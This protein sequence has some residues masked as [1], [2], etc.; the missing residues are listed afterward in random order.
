LGV[1]EAPRSVI[2]GSENK[3]RAIERV[4][5]RVCIYYV[6]LLGDGE[7]RGKFN[8]TEIWYFFTEKSIIFLSI[9]VPAPVLWVP[10]KHAEKPV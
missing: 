5:E 1:G 9:A 10:K 4:M 3:T 7:H 8:E 6:L 2:A